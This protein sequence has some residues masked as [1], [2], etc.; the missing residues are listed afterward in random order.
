M[1]VRHHRCNGHKLGELW[2]MERAGEAWPAA[3]QEAQKVGHDPVTEQ[4]QAA[5]S[6][7]PQ[8]KCCN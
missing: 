4:P 2:E 8:P 6:H 5:R 1:A 3:V 7:T